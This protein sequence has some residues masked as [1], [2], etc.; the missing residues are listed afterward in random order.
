MAATVPSLSSPPSADPPPGGLHPRD[1]RTNT[2]LAASIQL[3]A[4]RFDVFLRDVSSTGASMEGPRLPE[5]GEEVMLERGAI[6][7][8]AVVIWRQDRRCGIQFRRPVA[9]A[10]MMRRVGPGSSAHQARIDTAQRKI[11]AGTFVAPVATPQ[12][13]APDLRSDFGYAC[14]LVEAVG[15]ELTGDAYILSRYGT[16]LQRLDELMQLLKKLEIAALRDRS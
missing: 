5:T 14:R 2:M 9:V 3:G 1:P 4:D 8:G 11:R 12:P 13:A 7:V 6:Q 10:E 16:T 15:D